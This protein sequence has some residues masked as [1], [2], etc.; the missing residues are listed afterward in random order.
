MALKREVS[1]EGYAQ[2]VRLLDS[3]SD[4]IAFVAGI[5]AGKTHVACQKMFKH[6]ILENPGASAIVTAPNYRIMEMATLPKYDQIFP[7]ELI[8]RRK[9]RPYPVWELHNGGKIYFY[10]TDN[11]ETIVGG[12]VAF[13]HMDEASLSPYLAYVNCKKRMRQRDKDGNVYPY[14]LWI[15]TT[16]RQLNWIYLQFGPESPDNHVVGAT[17][18][19][20]STIRTGYITHP[21]NRFLV[22]NDAAGTSLYRLHTVFKLHIQV[23]LLE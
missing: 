15:S 10:S 21:H 5:G 20:V 23:R 2:Q 12:E 8:K 22:N 11:P 16:P 17:T 18:A 1:L 4:E 7:S 3:T 6:L 13:V 14:Q 19:L 9:T